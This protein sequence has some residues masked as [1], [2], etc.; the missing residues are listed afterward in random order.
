MVSNFIL[1]HS[2]ITLSQWHTQGCRFCLATRSSIQRFQPR[3]PL[4]S[5]LT[6]RLCSQ[7]TRFHKNQIFSKT[8]HGIQVIRDKAGP[9]GAPAV[10]PP[11]P[12]H[13]EPTHDLPVAVPAYVALDRMVLRF[14]AYFKEAVHESR[15]E[16]FR[17]RKVSP[18]PL[19]ACPFRSVEAS[20]TVKLTSVVC[21]SL[22]SP[23]QYF[24]LSLHQHHSCCSK[25]SQRVS[26][27]RSGSVTC[28]A[29]W[30]SAECR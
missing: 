29:G 24:Q 30:R 20:R 8:N 22:A 28:I 12:Q 2:Q 13:D 7:Q 5:C 26:F 16:H 9:R 15:A 11:P 23:H 3:I 6:C 27:S 4:C 21:Y 25:A 19:A 1:F 17:V 18:M 10:V 14:F